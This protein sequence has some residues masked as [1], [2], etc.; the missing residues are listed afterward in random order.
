MRFCINTP[1]IYFDI[2][3]AMF[4]FLKKFKLYLFSWYSNNSSKILPSIPRTDNFAF[5][6][7]SFSDIAKMILLDRGF[8]NLLSWFTSFHL[9]YTIFIIY[10]MHSWNKVPCRWHKIPYLVYFNHNYRGKN[11]KIVNRYC[12]HR[13]HKVRLFVKTSQYVVK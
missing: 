7:Q 1:F 8:S 9:N 12:Y 4:P 6:Q 13:L 10:K 11:G 3:I 5:F 2:F